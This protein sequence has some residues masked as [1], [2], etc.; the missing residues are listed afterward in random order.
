MWE[1]KT[2]F[3]PSLYGHHRDKDI[4]LVED[5]MEQGMDMLGQMVMCPRRQRS[6][7]SRQ[8]S[9][10]RGR[11]VVQGGRGVVAGRN[12]ALLVV[13]LSEAASAFAYTRHTA[14][15]WDLAHEGRYD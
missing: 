8:R 9:C 7:P 12:L 4:V 1:S 5:L 10:S 2:S 15:R 14:S 13:S 11:G 6:S 3:I